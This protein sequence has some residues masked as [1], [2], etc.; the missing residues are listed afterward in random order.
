MCVLSVCLS[1]YLCYVCAHGDCVGAHACVC[2]W[3]PE[4]S[5]WMAS[6]TLHFVTGSLTEP[7]VADLARLAGQ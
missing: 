2:M 5:Y 4:V 3:R 7:E 6:P 1:V